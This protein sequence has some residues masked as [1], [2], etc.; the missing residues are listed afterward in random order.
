MA[1]RDGTRRV[2]V[3]LDREESAPEHWL[4]TIRFSGFTVL[5]LM[6]VILAVMSL[7]SWYIIVTRP[8][9]SKPLTPSG[10]RYFFCGSAWWVLPSPGDPNR[11]GLLAPT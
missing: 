1:T 2:P 11:N 9:Q 5:M 3:T 4:R 10:A 7:G 8:E 6:L